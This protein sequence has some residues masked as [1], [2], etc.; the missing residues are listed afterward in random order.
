M[1]SSGAKSIANESV[2]HAGRSAQVPPLASPGS[3]K[4]VR[5]RATA[6]PTSRKESRGCEKRTCADR[7]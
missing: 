1:A 4:T 5:S 7:A 6:P 2:N 3:V